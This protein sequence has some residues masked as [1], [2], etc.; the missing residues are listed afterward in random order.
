MVKISSRSERSS[1]GRMVAIAIAAEAPQMAVAPPVRTPRRR[2][3]PSA[4][5]APIPKAMVTTTP[6]TMSPPLN[7]PSPPICSNV[8]RAPSSATPRRRIRRAAKSTPG[9]A[10]P[11]P[12]TVLSAMPSSS[13]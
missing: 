10:R 6:A 12:A 1:R 8:I 5:A 13:A 3:S 9:F 4:F 2:E 11:S 7:Q